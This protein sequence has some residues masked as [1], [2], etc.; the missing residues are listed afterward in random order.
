MNFLTLP[1]YVLDDFVEWTWV[2]APR[3]SRH[4]PS[5]KSAKTI[6]IGCVG[7]INEEVHTDNMEIRDAVE[8]KEHCYTEDGE[9]IVCPVC[10]TTWLTDIDGDA[11]F[12]SC[13]HLRFSLHSECDGDFEFFGEWDLEDFLKLVEKAREKDDDMH[14]LDILSEIQHLDVD[15]TMIFVWQE[16]PLNH[17][18][19]IWGYNE[20]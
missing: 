11:N 18:W 4:P 20:D 12:D 13:K 16:D 6:A 1:R 17:P 5:K 2:F 19:M 7:F 9:E 14:I 15:K 8:D 10:G 3:S